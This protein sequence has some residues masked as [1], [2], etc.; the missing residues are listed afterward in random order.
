MTN[1]IICCTTECLDCITNLFSKWFKSLSLS[2]SYCLVKTLPLG[3]HFCFYSNNKIQMVTMWLWCWCELFQLAI[4]VTPPFPGIINMS[5]PFVTH[6]LN[7]MKFSTHDNN[8]DKSGSDCAVS[9]MDGGLISVITLTWTNNL[10]MYILTPKTIICSVL[11]WREDTNSRTLYTTGVYTDCVTLHHLLHCCTL[12]INKSF[13][14][15]LKVF[16][17]LC[18]LDGRVS[19]YEWIKWYGLHALPIVVAISCWRV[20]PVCQ[21]CWYMACTTMGKGYPPSSEHH[22]AGLS[23][24]LI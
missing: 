7:R 23:D 17:N 24:G 19:W 1:Y 5:D 10:H 21:Y 6:L 15:N 3:L 14:I 8:N 2:I 18:M 12:F 22:T 11:K 16:I 13:S 9:K 4:R 20:L